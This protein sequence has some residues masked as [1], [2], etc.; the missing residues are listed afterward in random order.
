MDETSRG[1]STEQ[2]NA[3]YLPLE[4]P[5]VIFVQY[6]GRLSNPAAILRCLLNPQ[7]HP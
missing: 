5:Y 3:V 7:A 2:A 4:M 6:R 1:F